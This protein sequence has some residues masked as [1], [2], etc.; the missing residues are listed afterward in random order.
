LSFLSELKRRNVFRVAA[1]YIVAAWLVI[2]VVETILPAFGFGDAAVRLVVIVFAIGL[3]PTLILSWAF[4]L[5]P[6][7]LKRESEL[8]RERP[9]APGAGKKLDRLIMVI[10]ALAVAYFLFDR[11]VLSPARETEIAAEA[12]Q[13]GAEQALQDVRLGMWNEK[14]IAVLPFSNR[15]E[16]KEDEYFTDGMHDEL[17]TRLSRIGELKVISR[18]SVME[19]RDT[20]KKIPDIARE[21][22][23]AHV[24]EGGVQ[25]AGNQ[26]RINVQLI[27]A[28][29]DEHLWAEIY[30]R[31]LTTENL[32]AI[33]TE[34]STTIA[35]SLNAAISPRERALV[36]DKPTDSL[37]AYTLYLQG[38]QLLARRIGDEVQRALAAFEQAVEIDPEFAL[39]WVGIADARMLMGQFGAPSAEATAERKAAVDRALALNDQLGEAYA[40]LAQVLVWEDDLEGAEAAFRR[41]IELNPND[42]QA[43]M[44]YA[45]FPH[46]DEQ[47]ELVLDLLYRAARLDPLSMVVQA[48]IGGMLDKMGRYEEARE[49]Y[50]RMLEMD[51]GFPITYLAMGMNHI[52]QGELAQAARSTRQ[53]LELDRQ[54]LGAHNRL[55]E[56]YLSLGEFQRARAVRDG[57]AAL[58]AEDHH[59]PVLMDYWIHMA[60]AQWREAL[61]DMQKL[62][63]ARPDHPVPRWNQALAYA[64][65]DEPESAI[66]PLLA[67]DPRFADRSAWPELLDGRPS[68]Q[69]CLPAGMLARGGEEAL[70]RDLAQA[71]IRWIDEFKR[72]KP[73]YITEYS[74]FNAH[75]WVCL[76][77]LGQ[78]D[79]AVALLREMPQEFL[80]QWQWV[81]QEPWWELVREDPEFRKIAAALDAK[82]AEQRRLLDELESRDPPAD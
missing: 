13:A 25:R 53:G 32:F 24:L 68:E 60:Q 21:L 3:V 14:S 26:V 29:T 76:L 74:D 10:L 70:G 40:A 17:L 51:P 55:L 16:L 39:A 19:Y 82:I 64:F 58:V 2:Q 47:D 69:A 30:D 77:V 56:L 62:I 79:E 43:H 63:E 78:L 28:P 71:T 44:W 22:G 61:A 42:A 5:T 57:L 67:V 20:L 27:H 35:E 33:Q 75:R 38:R 7:G 72:G 15:S 6:E 66:E 73:E 18:T 34:I 50:L 81:Q 59:R 54:R 1:A 37:E 12:R 49:V 8:D 41:A 45:L 23:V 65:G 36:E 9:L 46:G 11:L 52:N 80:L 4:E 31:E 48:N